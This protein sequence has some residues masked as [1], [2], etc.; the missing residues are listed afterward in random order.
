MILSTFVSFNNIYFN[1]VIVK[2]NAFLWY[3]SSLLK[4]LWN[5][6]LV[7]FVVVVTA[8]PESNS[9]YDC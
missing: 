2:Q 8:N 9:Y 5:A 6:E 3:F 1:T 4:I 7:L